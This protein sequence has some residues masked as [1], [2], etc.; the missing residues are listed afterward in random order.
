MKL[1][2]RKLI[3]FVYA[4]RIEALSVVKKNRKNVKVQVN[5]GQ[6]LSCRSPLSVSIWISTVLIQGQQQLFDIAYVEQL[7]DDLVYDI[8]LRSTQ[9]VHVNFAYTCRLLL[10]ICRR[11][12]WVGVYVC[13]CGVV[14]ADP[15]GSRKTRLHGSFA[16]STHTHPLALVLTSSDV[17]FTLIS[18][19]QTQNVCF[20]A[21]SAPSNS[22]S[23]S[24]RAHAFDVFETRL[25]SNRRL[26]TEKHQ[27]TI[28]IVKWSSAWAVPVFLIDLID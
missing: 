18:A 10:Q 7:T 15:M 21:P 11:H 19:I 2:L 4:W 20:G 14:T 28:Q 3:L 16:L 6:K 13:V 25:R 8:V 5:V 24:V 22:W 1:N 26:P 23:W 12:R 27:Q 17:N 9:S